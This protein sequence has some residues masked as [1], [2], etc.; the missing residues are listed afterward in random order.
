MMSFYIFLFKSC[1]ISGE[2]GAGKTEST[3]FILQYLCAVTS[4]V[5]TWIQEQILEAHTILE[6]FGN[7]IYL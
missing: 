7:Y 1:L 2:S 5:S 3:K 4:D 6:A